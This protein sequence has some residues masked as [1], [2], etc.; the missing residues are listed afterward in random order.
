M[1]ATCARVTPSLPSGNPN[2]SRTDER[3]VQLTQTDGHVT[4]SDGHND[5]PVHHMISSTLARNK[6]KD[7]RSS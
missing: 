3:H 7:L 2:A 1:S 4:R 6:A 5:N